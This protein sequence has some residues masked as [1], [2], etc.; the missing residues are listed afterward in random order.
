MNRNTLLIVD[1]MEVNRAILRNLFAK[2]FNILE[3]QNGEQVKE[4]HM[5]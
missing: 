2:D 4:I 1:D 3:A 5:K